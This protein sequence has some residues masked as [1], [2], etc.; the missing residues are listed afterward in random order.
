MRC[1]LPPPPSPPLRLLLFLL[2]CSQTHPPPAP[3]SL[4]QPLRGPPPQLGAVSDPPPPSRVVSISISGVTGWLCGWPARCSHPPWFPSLGLHALVSS[5][6]A[7]ESRTVNLRFPLLLP[8]RLCP[9]MPTPTLCTSPT[10]RGCSAR[11]ASMLEVRL[12]RP[13]HRPCTPTSQP[14][15]LPACLYIPDTRMQFSFLI[16]FVS[17]A[18]SPLRKVY[19][20]IR[21]CTEGGTLIHFYIYINIWACLR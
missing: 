2:L 15:S 16:Y 9:P 12:H 3:T 19:F 5:P 11:P 17:W 8:P 10:S 21:V 18:P 6:H 14:A 7:S 13:M 20:L 4:A 1:S